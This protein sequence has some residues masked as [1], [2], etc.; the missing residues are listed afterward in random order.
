MFSYLWLDTT[1]IG[2]PWISSTLIL[3]LHTMDHTDLFLTVTL[4]QTEP[5]GWLLSDTYWEVTCSLL[6]QQVLLSPGEFVLRIKFSFSVKQNCDFWGRWVIMQLE[7]VS[8]RNTRHQVSQWA[9][10]SLEDVIDAALLDLSKLAIRTA[11]TFFYQ[12]Q[13]TCCRFT[14]D[15]K[16]PIQV[17]FIY[18]MKHM[19][20]IFIECRV[21]SSPS[22]GFTGFMCPFCTQIQCTSRWHCT[23][24]GLTLRIQGRG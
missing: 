20:T 14:L 10:V 3:I 24:S 9:G 22:N 4:N 19:N 6:G 21:C 16:Q 12:V 23:P 18:L 15:L 1:I 13:P 8:H 2:R 11:L 5:A 7:C 17:S